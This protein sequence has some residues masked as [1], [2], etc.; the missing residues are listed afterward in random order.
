[1][2]ELITFTPEEQ[3][4]RDRLARAAAADA[5]RA[6][7]WK[8]R[9]HASSY[10]STDI[11]KRRQ[12]AFRAQPDNAVL[13]RGAARDEWYSRGIEAAADDL[14]EMLAIEYEA[15]VDPEPTVNAPNLS[16]GEPQ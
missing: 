10:R 2:P 6:A 8:L 12:L 7:Y 11:F 5:I 1:M 13:A 3:Y 9:G 15:D 16:G 4:E 14:G